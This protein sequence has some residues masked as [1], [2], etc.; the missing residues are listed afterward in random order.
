LETE[1]RDRLGPLPERELGVV[2]DQRAREEELRRRE[3]L[4][5]ERERFLEEAMAL[6]R[7]QV[8]PYPIESAHRSQRRSPSPRYTDD[9]VGRTGR[10]SPASL[11]RVRYDPP[12]KDVMGYAEP[13]SSRASRFD[14]D[15]DGRKDPFNPQP[16]PPGDLGR[17]PTRSG[18]RSYSPPRRYSP[19]PKERFLP[20]PPSPSGIGADIYRDFRREAAGKR[21]ISPSDEYRQV[22]KQYKYD[23]YKHF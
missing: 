8:S 7:R 20:R 15:R 5:R 13:A 2:F 18:D 17:I 3:E 19:E 22:S 9:S 16:S 4:L 1:K 10:M 12:L 14:F 6:R 23:D 21:G 11:S